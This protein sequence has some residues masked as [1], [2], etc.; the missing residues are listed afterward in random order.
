M[1][2]WELDIATQMLLSRLWRKMLM[3]QHSGAHVR[4]VLASFFVQWK[5]VETCVHF[6]ILGSVSKDVIGITKQNDAL[7]PL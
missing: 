5:E 4:D 3:L 2:E 6:H 7:M 1:Y